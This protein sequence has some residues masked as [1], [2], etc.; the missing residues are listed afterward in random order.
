MVYTAATQLPTLAIFQ[1]QSENDP[2]PS[3]Q[4]PLTADASDNVV[5]FSSAP[6]DK[7]GNVITD[8][9]LIGVRNQDSLVEGIYCPN[10]ADGDSGLS[11]TGCIRGIRFHGLDYTTSGGANYIFQADEGSP[12]FCH[13]S[14][15]YHLIMQGVVQGSIA[16]GGT[17]LI[18]GDGTNTNATI[19]HKDAAGTKGFLRKN[20]TTG[21]AEYSNDGAVWNAIDNVVAG[22]LVVVSADDTTPSNL[23]AKL[24]DDP[25][26][27]LTW[28]TL[29]PGGNET[30]QPTVNG[31]LGDMI[32][33][34]TATAAEINNTIDGTTATA[35]NLNTLTGGAA[36][37]AD[38]LH[39]HSGLA[40]IS[41]IAGEDLVVGDPVFLKGLAV[42]SVA[43]DK[44]NYIDSSNAT[45]VYN[46]T[47]LEVDIT[48]GGTIK[49]S[50]IHFDIS[51]YPAEVTKAFLR[52]VS[53][54]QTNI[55]AVDHAVKVFDLNG[56]FD[57]ATVTWNTQPGVNAESAVAPYDTRH[58]YP[59]GAGVV[60]DIT[61]IY[62]D[63][64]SVANHGLSIRWDDESLPAGSYRITPG[65]R[66]HGTA[67]YRP[68][69]ILI[70]ED[71]DYLKAFKP[72]SNAE[73]AGVKGVV[74]TAA[75][76]GNTAVIALDGVIKGLAGLTPHQLLKADNT[77]S[78]VA[79][80]NALDAQFQALSATE[81]K[82][83]DKRKEYASDILSIT[84]T[85]YDQDKSIVEIPGGLISDNAT[86]TA[87]SA[88][89]EI[90]P[91]GYAISTPTNNG[92]TSRS[93]GISAVDI[94]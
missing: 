62:N 39:T 30:R 5:Y 91:L 71:S 80:T 31:L 88:S 26:G 41:V 15:V 86:A 61:D 12:V 24:V 78:L 45:T 29:N 44:D 77:G 70:Y 20:P 72:S 23:E 85:I 63:N 17:G 82:I 94:L 76:S 87:A 89:V 66:T 37:S 3:I 35:A 79:A 21:K 42:A 32:S 92:I 43:P 11:A 16:T 58:Q 56:D 38:G 18:I 50:L 65:S 25:N 54:N 6:L 53:T 51:A 69:L 67:A 28:A 75:T 84:A 36:S 60:I 90:N 68:T 33:D 48:A 64:W 49:R 59:A 52:L 73:A 9:F 34:V 46:G 55:N 10:G 74:T 93:V 40:T 47:T 14:A 19:S 81:L 57:E 27:S 1:W 7:D 4:A 2:N 8:P 22:S 83:L 13:V